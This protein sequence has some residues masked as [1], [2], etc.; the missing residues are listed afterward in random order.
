MQHF[1]VADPDL[2]AGG[3]LD[4]EPHD[5]GGREAVVERAPPGQDRAAG[6]KS[7][8]EYAQHMPLEKRQKTLD[9]YNGPRRIKKMTI[10]NTDPSAPFSHFSIVPGGEHAEEFP[11][12][13]G[14]TPRLYSCSIEDGAL[15]EKIK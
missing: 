13:T 9:E 4:L 7:A 2:R 11:A 1:A 3:P 10:V 8:P 14:R 6:C 5:P 12:K 15:A